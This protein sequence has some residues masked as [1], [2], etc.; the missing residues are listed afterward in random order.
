MSVIDIDFAIMNEIRVGSTAKARRYTKGKKMWNEIAV[1]IYKKLQRHLATIISELVCYISS[2]N[3]RSLRVEWN[4]SSVLMW[5][6]NNYLDRDR[7]L[8][9][10]VNGWNYSFFALNVDCNFVD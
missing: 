4:C 1:C 8:S 6:R 10:T 7:E 2:N 5:V 3:W 9:G